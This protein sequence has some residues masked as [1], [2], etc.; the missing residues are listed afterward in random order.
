MRIHMRK[1]TT[2]GILFGVLG[3]SFGLSR[4][5]PSTTAQSPVDATSI[6]ISAESKQLQATALSRLQAVLPGLRSGH[7][8]MVAQLQLKDETHQTPRPFVQPVISPSCPHSFTVPPVG[9]E[10]GA[11]AVANGGRRVVAPGLFNVVVVALSDSR[12]SALV[13]PRGWA[14][15]PFEEVCQEHGCAQVSTALYV[16]ERVLEDPLALRKALE[17]SMGWAPVLDYPNGHPPSEDNTTKDG[18]KIQP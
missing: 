2:L 17:T 3:A 4:V 14:V 11:R 8:A 7:D 16:A 1:I 12:A 13:G 5:V 18:R 9:A 6:C 10:G 15:G